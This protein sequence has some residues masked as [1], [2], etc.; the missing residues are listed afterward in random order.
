MKKHISFILALI[1]ILSSFTSVFAT[2]TEKELYEQAGEILKNVDVLEGSKSGD[3]MLNDKLKRQDMVVLISRLYKQEDTAKNY[4]GKNPFKDVT[5]PFYVPYI[6]WAV[7]K[8]LIT[9]MTSTKFGYGEPVTVQQLQT[10]LLRALGYGEEAKNWNNVP[11]FAES[12]GIMEGL[13]TTPKQQVQRGLMAAMTVNT[14]R[15]T[16]K[17]ESITLAEHLGLNIPDSFNV[18]VVATIDK[19]TLRLEGKATGVKNL[20]VNLKPLFNDITV[21][22]KTLDI[23]LSE[24]G[25]FLIEIPNLKA[26]TYEYKFLSGNLS[27]QPKT[28]NINDIPFEIL[29]VKAPN[30]KEIHINF[31]KPVDKTCTLF[32]GNYYTD[33]GE[34]KSVRTEDDDTTV[35][36]TLKDT[37]D[38]NK[39]YKLS[40]IKVKSQDNKEVELKDE[41]FIAYDNEPPKARE[42]KA[43]GNKGIRVYLSEPVKSLK[44]SNFKID[45]KNVLGQVEQEENIVTI[46]FFSSYTPKEGNHELTLTGLEDFA[47]Y[48]GLDQHF[49]FPIVKDNEK[50]KIIDTI[51]TLDEVIIQF[52]K[53]ID[54]DSISKNNFY[55][56]LGYSKRYA[57]EV[58]VLNDK[59]I[60]RFSKDNL[61]TNEV[62]I[63]IDSVA[64]YWGNKL[65]NEQIKVKPEIDMTPPEVLGVK[66]SE[67]GKAITVY[68]T[69]NVDANNRAFYSIKDE[70]NKTV[71][72][73][74]IEGSGRK[75]TIHLYAPLSVGIN[76]ITIQDVC[77]TTPL[78]NKLIPF[79][80]DIYMKDVEKPVI[81]SYSG[82]NNQIIILFSKDMDPETLEKHENYLIKL[83]DGYTYIPKDTEFTLID[84]KTLIINLP[85]KINGQLVS[86]GY[87]GNI[88]EMQISGLKGTNGVLMEP[89]FIKF[90]SSTTGTAKV[91]KAELIEP[92]VIKVTF[93]QPILYAHPNDF[94]IPGKTIYDVKV[95][96]SNE[97]L[98]MLYEDDETTIS[99]NLYI[100]K[101]NSIETILGTNVASQTISIEDKVAPR[102]DSKTRELNVVGNKI[103]LPFTEPLDSR[104]QSLFGDDLE[105][106]RLEDG[107]V[108]EYNE[109]STYLKTGDNS[110]LIIEIKNPPITSSYRIR[111]KS[112]PIYIRDTNGNIVEENIE[113]YFTNREIIR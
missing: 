9:G 73:K 67:D 47:G 75:Y 85:E 31:S 2:N 1:M 24:D 87:K 20:K 44:T 63:Y 33:A 51:A 22:E 96:F 112:E 12:L 57:D 13:T 66:V 95:N 58:K 32:P 54:P 109:Y 62:T 56:K 19:N 42:I 86:V 94:S 88:K 10:V 40:I 8:G 4:K 99:K 55:W 80:Y 23:P 15:L 46:K 70:K 76:T 103:E 7:D 49:T 78:K 37:M 35:V 102:I 111:L 3:L 41:K 45:G 17:G 98:L 21:K 79:T 50:P 110:I 28:I 100:E 34:V 48:K 89:A 59:L 52:D 65:T 113:D 104:A 64:D 101:N 29:E 36:L 83:G 39:E 18:D 77:D 92:D 61:P 69:K 43:L 38:N 71:N 91:E 6:A 14:L 53:E 26:G 84:G 105:I 27:T 82:E 5:N 97:L 81:E 72:I 30:L 16:M 93:N 107:H 106:L 74:N 108:L 11:D 60:L 25:T 68:F 90:T